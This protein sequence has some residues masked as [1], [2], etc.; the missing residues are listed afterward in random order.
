MASRSAAYVP[1]TESISD[2]D[3]GLEDL[4]AVQ[5]DGFQMLV[6]KRVAL[7]KGWFFSR[8]DIAPFPSQNFFFRSPIQISGRHGDQASAF[9]HPCAKEVEDNKLKKAE[10]KWVE[11]H[12]QL[13]KEIFKKC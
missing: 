6:P 1:R 12:K 3:E 8:A 7:A 11:L 4:V 13:M 2:P 9:H 5:S 10:M